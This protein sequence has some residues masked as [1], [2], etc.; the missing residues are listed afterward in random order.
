M[1]I[2]QLIIGVMGSKDR[3]QSELSVPLGQLIARK[4]F[5]LLTGGAQGVM[6]KV[7][8]AFY[9]VPKSERQGV[10]IGVIPTIEEPNGFFKIREGYP[11]PF[12]E[13]PIITPLPISDVNNPALINRNHVNI[14]TSDIVIALPGGPGTANE[15]N[16]ALKFGKPLI[17][18]DPDNTSPNFPPSVPRALTINDIDRFLNEQSS[19]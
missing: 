4:G 7:S 11:N 9:S 2:R 6:K 8:E 13:V 1:Q 19:G 15:I 14:L 5:H 18:F 12:V 3:E 10:T 16:L 17:L